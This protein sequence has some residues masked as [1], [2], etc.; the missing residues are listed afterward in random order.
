MRQMKADMLLFAATTILFVTFLL[1]GARPAL[2]ETSIVDA[3]RGGVL[4]HDVVEANRVEQ[5]ADLNGEIQFRPL[6]LLRD[7]SHQAWVNALLDPRPVIG[8]SINVSGYTSQF[9]FGATWHTR[10]SGIRPGPGFYGELSLGGA[11]HNGEIGAG[12]PHREA[13]GS[14]VLFHLSGALGYAISAHY[15]LE[16]YYEH[17]SNGGLAKYNRSL[18]DVGLRLGYRF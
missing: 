7:P 4:A 6:G 14:R 12:H 11:I 17:D 16:A 18:N 15:S 1:A 10:L 2:A 3:V 13:L 9:Y 8:A 5:G